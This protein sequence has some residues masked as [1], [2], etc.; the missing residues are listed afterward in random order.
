[1]PVRKLL[2]IDD[3]SRIRN[4]IRLRMQP[5]YQ[6]FD[7]DDP[8]LAL[9]HALGDKP[10]AILLD[11][12]MPR[13]SGFELCQS[14]HSLSY[15]SHIPIFV[16]TGESGIK[17]REHCAQLGAVDYFEKPIDFS[18]LRNT[19]EDTLRRKNPIRTDSVRIKLQV[20]VR[21]TG[22]DTN[23]TTFEETTTTE[24]VSV[25]GFLCACA[26]SLTTDAEVGV[27]LTGSQEHFVGRARV[28]RKE[29]SSVPWQ[30]YGFRFLEKNNQWVLS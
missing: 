28:A 22:K 30:K 27:Y 19:L 16:V 11:L 21:L 20:P 23:G 15:T 1:M 17:Y 7:T 4:L 18:K 2:I 5:E 8:Q 24:D 29:S 26:A 25:D 9:A 13:L 14:F 10:D 12:M 3:D 6:V